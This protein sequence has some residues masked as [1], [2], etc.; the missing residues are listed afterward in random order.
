MTDDQA[1]VASLANDIG[2]VVG[3]FA[4]NIHTLIASDIYR[5]LAENGGKCKPRT[6][7]SISQ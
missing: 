7:A 6:L 2:Q 5:P 1:I 3:D 4:G